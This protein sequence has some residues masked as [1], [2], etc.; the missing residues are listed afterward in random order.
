MQ[1]AVRRLSSADQ[2][3]GGKLMKQEKLHYCC[4]NADTHLQEGC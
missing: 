3:S 4:A 2:N 1:E